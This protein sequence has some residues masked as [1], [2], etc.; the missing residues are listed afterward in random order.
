MKK[1]R[2]TF[3]LIFSVIALIAVAL[4]FVFFM[5]IIKN[6]NQ[7]IS[8]A[9]TALEE[10]MKEKE[11]AILNASKVA[12][13]KSIQDLIDSHFVDPDKIDTFV[14]Y[15]EG[16]GSTTGSNVVIG[17]INVPQDVKNTIAFKVS[18]TGSFQSV[19]K[20][21]NFI[22]NIPYQ[23]SITQVYLNKETKSL[24]AE[25]NPKPSGWQADI[26]FNVLSLN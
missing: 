5:R 10:K 18:V 16:I 20:T 8:V 12:E 24:V 23:V 25:K 11:D 19:M 9:A 1:T 3:F 6:K 22:D 17:G 15:L 4:L 26:S 14:N 7:H 2:T 13:I 21:I